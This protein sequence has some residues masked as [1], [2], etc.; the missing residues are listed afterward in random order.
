VTA[1][2]E[3]GLS[4]AGLRTK[5]L[6]IAAFYFASGL[7]FGVVN[8]LVPIY[9]RDSGAELGDIARLIGIAGYAWTLKFLWAP[10]VDRFGTRK[11][12]IVAT[13]ALL[14]LAIGLLALADPRAAGT[15]LL[16]LLVAV[17]ALSA[18][19][20]ITL[21]AYAIEILRERE[22]GPANGVR[23]TAYRASLLVAG[24]LLV[25]LAAATGWRTIFLVGAG[26]MLA[27]ALLSLLAPATPRGSAH[28]EPIWRP[29]VAFL[30]RRH[31]WAIILFALTF[32]LGDSAMAVMAE[33]F[34]VDA[35]LTLPQIGLL[36]T[37]AIGGV[38]VGALLGG[39]LIARWGTYRALWALGGVQALSNLGYVLA[40]STAPSV[41]LIGGAKVFEYFTA[42]LGTA[43]FL[44]FLMS[45]CE[46][47]Y[48]ATQYALL[49][50]LY[51]FGRQT[52]IG[53]SGDLTE[54]LGYA[55]YFF[56]TFL[57]ALPAFALLPWIR[58]VERQDVEA[59]TE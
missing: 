22:M 42:G 43:A 33:T 11:G 3:G 48:A 16:A 54:G 39:V 17:A 1:R 51:G 52:A 19:Q 26:V 23:V 45:I 32:K 20:D 37:L 44:T 13:Q 29:L 31:L 10:L 56:L 57:L 49:S 30:G 55:T 12:W 47:R 14:G 28:H 6:W 58:R 15:F 8:N 25:A 53:V 35:G 18:T 7:P 40:A 34:L 27:F 9:F 2:V 41:W 36:G 21:D 46:K 24:G 4:G 59:I 5:L 50:A 38:V